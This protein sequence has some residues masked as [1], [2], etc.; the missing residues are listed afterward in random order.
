MISGRRKRGRHRLCGYTAASDAIGRQL[1]LIILSAF[2]GA[3]AYFFTRA[4]PELRDRLRR[5]ARCSSRWRCVHSRCALAWAHDAH[6]AHR[7][8][9]HMGRLVTLSESALRPARCLAA[10][11][12]RS[13][14]LSDL[15][16]VI[17]PAGAALLTV[18]V[19]WTRLELGLCSRG[20][21]FDGSR[22]QPR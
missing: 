9:R 8:S 22:R 1:P 15:G 3:A 11:W 19:Y 12:V 5:R 2:S 13:G 14:R 21:L 16:G 17:V 6:E 10:C 7:R 20:R 4:C 18:T